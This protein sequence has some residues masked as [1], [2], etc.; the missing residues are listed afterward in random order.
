MTKPEV[1]PLGVEGPPGV[2]QTW[3]GIKTGFFNRKRYYWGF[4]F[5]HFSYSTGYLFAL[6]SPPHS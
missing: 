5:F 2:K 1:R 4:D 3:K 6:V